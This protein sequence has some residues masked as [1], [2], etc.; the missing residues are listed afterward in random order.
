MPVAPYAPMMLY[1]GTVRSL[2][3]ADQ[4]RVASALGAS[5]LTI[6][7][8]EYRALLDTGM[9]AAG[10]KARAADAGIRIDH[11]D[12]FIRWVPDSA[13]A[14]GDV[15]FASHPEADDLF[16]MAAALEARSVSVVG[17]FPGGA[18]GPGE[19]ADRFGQ[20]CGRAAAHGLR[21]D[22]EFVPIWGLPD[23][24]TAWR[25]VSQA[26][27]PNSGILLDMW[28]YS[29]GKPDDDLLRHIPG[30]FITCVQ[31][32]DGTAS[33]PPGRD[34]LEDTRNYRM[35]PGQGEFRVREIVAILRAT[36]GLNNVGPE[37]FSL[38]FDRMTAGQIIE[39]CRAGLAW[40]LDDAPTSR[41]DP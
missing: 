33:L 8:R 40:A 5:V 6:G 16:R 36:G 9:T 7:P 29:R 18:L 10:I 24:A 37:I 2:P 14:G 20:F 34:A 11:I 26:A 23:L 28:H 41:T 39:Q 31:L 21:C 12:P 38:A 35:P 19:M 27:A 4:L 3:L 30:R 13:F 22:L 17:M 15:P 32:N 25:I 1:H